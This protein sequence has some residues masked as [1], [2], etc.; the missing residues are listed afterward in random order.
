MRP[1]LIACVLGGT[2]PGARTELHDIAFVVGHSLD[3]VHEQLLDTWFGTPE[4]LHVDAWTVLDSIAGYRVHLGQQ[5]PGNGLHL[6]FVNIGGYL[7]GEFG[8]RHAWGFFGAS[9]RAEAKARAKAT[10]LPG[11]QTPH[12]DDLYQVDDCIQIDAIERWHI[13]LQPDPGATAAPV[14]NGYNPLPAATIRNWRQKR[15]TR[16]SGQPP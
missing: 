13:Q 16:A 8:E 3:A 9:S 15:A 2:A 5:A 12:K 14:T 7:P 1:K 11:H 10:L 6:Y 4:G